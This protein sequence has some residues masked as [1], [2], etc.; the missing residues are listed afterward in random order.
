MAD[1]FGNRYFA[2]RYFAPRYWGG[3][4][5]AAG[6]GLVW[7]YR[8]QAKPARYDWEGDGGLLLGGIAITR[9]DSAQAARVRKLKLAAFEWL[10][11][12]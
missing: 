4:Q 5:A 10:L 3:P 11:A 8:A 7:T 6:A 2:P 12:A 1:Y 9:L